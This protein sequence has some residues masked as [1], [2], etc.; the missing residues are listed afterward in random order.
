MRQELQRRAPGTVARRSDPSWSAV[1]S[2]TMRLW[3]DRHYR[4]RAG[5]R[6]LVLLL[7][8]VVAMAFGAG[9]TLAFTQP[10]HGTTT[11]RASATSADALQLA[12]AARQQAAAWIV[13]E[14]ASDIVVGCDLEMCNELQKSGF[15]AARLLPLQ[16]SAPDPLGAQ[17]VVATPVIRN[18]FGTR[19]ATVYAPL[20]IAGFG[21]GPGRVEVRYIAPDGSKVF[22]AQL[23]TY[24]RNRITAGRQLLGNN[25]VQASAI[26]RRELLGGQ[27]DPRLLVTLSTLADLMPL[28]LIAFDDLSPG[29]STDVPMRGA[30]LGAAASTGLPAM[31]AFMRAQQGQFA[32]AVARITRDASGQHVF[33][34]RYAAPGPMGLEGS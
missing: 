21:S 11:A 10:E 16:P 25:H 32:P 33:I 23:A 24:R 1:A 15:P 30:E 31:V 7:S 34:V 22:E 26:A 9:V 5:R 4:R 17:L 20:V 29:A 12:A 8:A 28:R 19:L 3:L 13:R 18:Q 2:T 14:V 27:V 6:R